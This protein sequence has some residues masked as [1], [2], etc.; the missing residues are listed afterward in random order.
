MRKIE[1][2]LINVEGKSCKG[3]GMDGREEDQVKQAKERE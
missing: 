3:G 1:R 2:R